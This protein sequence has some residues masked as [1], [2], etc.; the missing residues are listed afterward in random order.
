[1][2]LSTDTEGGCCGGRGKW[3]RGG[4]CGR[5]S[6]RKGVKLEGERLCM[7]KGCKVGCSKERRCMWQGCIRGMLVERDVA[8]GRVARGC[9]SG[10]R[11]CTC[12]SYTGGRKGA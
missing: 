12:E 2:V 4:A 9:P 3:R 10:E 6:G 5:G 8:R 1:M 11:R 7:W